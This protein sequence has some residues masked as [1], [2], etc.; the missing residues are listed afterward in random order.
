MGKQFIL[1]IVVV[2]ISLIM[3]ASC[4]TYIVEN[5]PANK[6][7]LGPPPHAPAYGYRRKQQT[8]VVVPV[9]TNT[10]ASA[11]LEEVRLEMNSVTVNITNSNG[12]ISPVTLKKQGI[13]YVG[14]KGE[15]YDHLPTESELKPVYGF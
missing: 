3:T 10:S 14:P 13:G 9:K 12:S 7:G 6:N 2:L 5:P 1:T 4:D 8:T 11:Q 15:F